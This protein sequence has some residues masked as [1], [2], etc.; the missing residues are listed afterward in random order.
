MI[1]LKATMPNITKG[2]L[3]QN[4]LNLLIVVLWVYN[5]IFFGTKNWHEIS[6][7][8]WLI[9]ILVQSYL[10][11]GIF[12]IVHDCIHGSLVR[13]NHKINNLVGTILSQMYGF[14]DYS[15]LKKN[16]F[17]HHQ[18]PATNDDP[19]Y[20]TNQ[21]FVVWYFN[22]LK[23][24]LSW[25]QFWLFTLVFAVAILIKTDLVSL[26]LIWRLPAI[27][28]S[29]QLFYFGVWLP[30]KNPESI[31]NSTKHNARNLDHPLLISILSCYNFGYHLHHHQKPNLSWWNLGTDYIAS[32]KR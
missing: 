21:N 2:L 26:L 29:L 5:L 18:N 12:I 15:I 14:I 23:G 19:D 27:F 10:Y 4:L 32:T 16:H 31:T 22:F 24:Y 1:E 11:T 28:S 20:S 3:T 6:W 17:L 30:H 25:K 8:S 7:Y 13:N 9:G